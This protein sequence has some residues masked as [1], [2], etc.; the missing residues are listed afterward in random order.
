MLEHFLKTRMHSSRM[1][2]ARMLPVSPSMHWSRGVYLPGGCTCPGVPAQGKCTCPGGYL[3][4]GVYLPRG[5]FAWGCTC[6]GV[7]LPRGSYLPRYS[8]LWT[9]FLTHATDNTTLP[10]TSFAGGNKI[11]KNYNYQFHNSPPWSLFDSRKCKNQHHRGSFQSWGKGY[12]CTLQ[13]LW[14]ES[15]RN[16]L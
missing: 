10:Q 8:P 5:V 2:N 11:P 9:E 14:E 16:F 4:G 3:P 6:L 13:Q 1:R 12:C 7:Y 15:Q